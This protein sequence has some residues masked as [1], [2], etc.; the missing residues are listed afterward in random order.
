MAAVRAIRPNELGSELDEHVFDRAAKELGHAIHVLLDESDPSPG[1]SLLSWMMGGN[2]Q[3]ADTVHPTSEQ[4]EQFRKELED[5]GASDTL[6]AMYNRS[7]SDY[8][9]QQY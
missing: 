9:I 2:L 3:L 7:P 1:M 4:L 8:E 5:G 6:V